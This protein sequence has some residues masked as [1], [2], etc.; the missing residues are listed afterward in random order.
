MCGATSESSPLFNTHNF[1]SYNPMTKQDV[2]NAIET[3]AAAK[4]TGNPT[5][6]KFAG[7]S[8][9]AMLEKLPEGDLTEATHPCQE[10]AGSGG[11]YE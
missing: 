6:I 9:Q 1:I 3:Y 8:L 7:F 11:G 5:L 10:V 4:S 2:A